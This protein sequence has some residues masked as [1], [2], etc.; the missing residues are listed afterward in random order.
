MV[1]R[2]PV[3]VGVADRCGAVNDEVVSNVPSRSANRAGSTRRSFDSALSD[4]VDSGT[5]PARRATTSPI[6]TATASSSV[7]ISGGIR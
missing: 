7:S 1:S 5:S 6:A 2:T 4:P 3:S